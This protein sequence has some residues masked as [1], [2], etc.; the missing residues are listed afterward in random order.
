[1][2]KG[3]FILFGFVFLG[4]QSVFCKGLSFELVQR[5][6]NIKDVCEASLVFEDEL[7]NCFFDSGFIVSNF[8]TV[9]SSSDK[10]DEKL[11]EKAFVQSSEG[12]AD[13]FVQIKL[14]FNN[15]KDDE[16]NLP[17]LSQIE[18]VSWKIVAVKDGNLINY[19]ERKVLDRKK[20]NSE[21]G[22][23]D[24]SAAFA[25]DLISFVNTKG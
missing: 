4:V 5:S 6:G 16:K 25:T 13:Y 11:F 2:K 22:I 8:P 12:L 7:M 15:L 1:M 20:L 23:K 14:F 3:F 9:V 24:F 18:K 10:N 19:G 21:F 17:S